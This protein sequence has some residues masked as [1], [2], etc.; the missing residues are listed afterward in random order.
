MEIENSR[1]FCI[2]CKNVII[3]PAE[4]QYQYHINCWNAVKNYKYHNSLRDTKNRRVNVILEKAF[5]L[6]NVNVYHGIIK[7]NLG[8]LGLIPKKTLDLF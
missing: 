8:F 2:Y 4:G 6:V 7:N 3:M 1:F 5:F